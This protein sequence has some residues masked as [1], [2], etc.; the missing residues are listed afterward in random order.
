MV[1]KRALLKT[2]RQ[3]SQSC[4][5]GFHSGPSGRITSPGWPQN[6]PNNT[7][8]TWNVTCNQQEAVHISFPNPINI[9]EKNA[10]H[11]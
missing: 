8:C 7:Q 3:N 11:W 4:G 6:Y 1:E 9:E 10:T 2:G 5:Q